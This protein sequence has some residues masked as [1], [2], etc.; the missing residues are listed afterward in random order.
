[1]KITNKFFNLVTKSLIG[2]EIV[3]KFLDFYSGNLHLSLNI[4]NTNSNI[5][6]DVNSGPEVRY[7]ITSVK[8]EKTTMDWL[9]KLDKD[10]TLFDIGANVGCY[11]LIAAKEFNIKKIHA[12][13]PFPINYSKCIQNVI[14]NN[15][16]DKISVYNFA[17]DSENKIQTLFHTNEYKNLQSGSSGHQIGKP[18]DENGI[19]FESD[20]EF[21]VNTYSID[22]LQTISKIS[23]PSYIKIDV[24]GRELEILKGAKETLSSGN[25]KS[26]MIEMNLKQK[27]IIDLLSQYGF[28]ITVNGEHGNTI[29]E[30]H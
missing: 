3:A 16:S 26:I 29:F 4:L 20:L 5:V 19:I 7:R 21:L 6:L 14:K 22:N 10:K 18:V 8:R 12:F 24:D 2:R 23:S 13:E 15:L 11:S 27:D 9:E 1:M 25:V 30:R 17:I 28:S